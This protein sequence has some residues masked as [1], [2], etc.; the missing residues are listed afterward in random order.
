MNWQELLKRYEIEHGKSLKQVSSRNKNNVVPE[1]TLCSTCDAPA[2][3]LYFNDGKK[4][5]QIKCKICNSFSTI[6]HQARK[7]DAKWYCPYCNSTLQLWKKRKDFSIFKCYNNNCSLYLSR[8]NKLNL[9]ETILA[10]IKPVQFKFRYHFREYHF[11]SEQ[12]QHSKPANNNLPH[13]SNIRNSL[14]TLGLVLTF[15]VSFAISARKTACILRDVFSI[16]ISYQSVLNYAQTAAHYCHTFNSHFKGSV[17]NEQAGDE[18]YIK[19]N[20]KNN[21]VFFFISVPSLKI[22]AY[23]VDSSRNTLPA[24]I[25]MNEAISN[26]NTSLKNTFFTDGNPSYQAALHFLNP[27]HNN[28]LELKQIIGLQNLDKQSEE[29]RPFK[30]IIE[31][32]NRTYKYH[33]KTANGFKSNNGAV[34]LTT[35]FTTHYNFLRP[36]YSLKYKTPIRLPF[37]HNINTIQ[38]RW[39]KIIDTGISLLNAA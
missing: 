33:I 3:Y 34:S 13:I 32:L 14:N 26:A 11:T 22:T 31:R 24:V 19:I 27:L 38:G 4:R 36:H 18:T 6:H 16:P 17:D 21:Y 12:L 28:N 5:S 9:K 23:H 25:A 8:K 35:L 10:K 39:A 30:Q 15:H 20:G 2:S 1:D 7:T 37:L 29:F